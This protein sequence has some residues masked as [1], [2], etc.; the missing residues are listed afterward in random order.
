[1]GKMGISLLN[2]KKTGEITAYMVMFIVVFIFMLF[3]TCLYRRNIALVTVREAEDSLKAATL[4]GAVV[5]LKIYGLNGKLVISDHDASYEIFKQSLTSSMGL[6]AD[7]MPD[8]PDVISSKVRVESYIIYNVD[9]DEVQQIMYTSDSSAPVIKTGSVGTVKTPSNVPVTKS[10]V[11][12]AISFQMHG[13]INQKS[14]LGHIF[15]MDDITVRRD[16]YTDITT[17]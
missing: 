16:S 10:S 13:F 8:S 5:D 17:R 12:S 3:S 4:A 6:G 14:M 1:M 7:F 11:Y 9:G 2:R 15:H